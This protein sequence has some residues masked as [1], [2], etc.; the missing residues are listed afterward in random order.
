[1]FRVIANSTMYWTIVTFASVVSIVVGTAICCVFWVASLGQPEARPL[2]DKPTIC[3]FEVHYPHSE[4]AVFAI[5][6]EG[7][8]YG[9]INRAVT[10]LKGP[11]R[12]GW[13]GH[14]DEANTA[15]ILAILR[16]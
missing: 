13:G 16:Q 6:F 8:Q 5:D 15:M 7:R 4:E 11:Q 9:D 1:M 14:G 2:A 12:C 3:A 10:L